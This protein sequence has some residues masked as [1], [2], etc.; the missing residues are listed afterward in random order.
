MSLLDYHS[1]LPPPIQ[2]LCHSLQLQQTTHRA[3]C[4]WRR[5][6]RDAE[7][8]ADRVT[9]SQNFCD[10]LKRT[11]ELTQA[12]YGCS[13]EVNKTLRAG[14]KQSSW[15][16]PFGKSKSSSTTQ[17]GFDLE[18]FDY[19]Y[20]VRVPSRKKKKKGQHLPDPHPDSSTHLTVSSTTW[21]DIRNWIASTALVRSSRSASECA[22]VGRADCLPAYIRIRRSMCR[23]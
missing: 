10:F 23:S 18:R 3:P 21:L 17:K 2:P 16:N 19:L 4:S 8:S 1:Y 13:K 15:L 12:L 14:H 7:I 20:H 22:R 6:T 11:A 9:A 5:V